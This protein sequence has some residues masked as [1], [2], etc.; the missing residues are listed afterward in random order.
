[1]AGFRIPLALKI[2]FLETVVI[3]SFGAHPS[4]EA[5]EDWMRTE[6]GNGY[7]EHLEK[8]M[9]LGNGLNTPEKANQEK[10][11][12]S[13][14]RRQ[15][16]ELL[17]IRQE[18]ELL[19]QRQKREGHTL[20]DGLPIFRQ[21]LTESPASIL[22][23]KD[24]A[25][26][27][28]MN[29]VFPYLPELSPEILN[30]PNFTW[31]A[32]SSFGGRTYLPYFTEDDIV[33]RVANFL[34]DVLL[35]L[36]LPL[37]LR[38]SLSVN[39]IRP[40]VSV[41]YAKNY[42][43]G[44]VEVR[45]TTKYVLESHPIVLGELLDQMLLVEG[46]YGMGPVIGILTTGEEWL[47]SWFPNDTM[48]FE[49]HDTTPTSPY[50]TPFIENSSATQTT[51][52]PPAIPSQA[53]CSLHSIDPVEVPNLDLEND[54]I[55]PQMHRML[56]TTSVL[57]IHDAPEVVLQ[58]LCGA[59]ELMSKS[60]IN[61]NAN[62]SRCLLKFHKDS[63]LITY[64]PVVFQD[65]YDS[66]NFHRFPNSNTKKLLALEDLGRGSNGIAWLCITLTRPSSVCV[67]KY[68]NH[69]STSH[70]EY[71]RNMWHFL[72]PEFTKMVQVEKWSGAFA[73]V[74]PH[75]SSV[76]EIEREDLRQELM[77]TLE[78]RFV[79]NRKVHQD[80]R[81]QNIGKYQKKEEGVGIILFD[82][83]S[84]VD[85]SDEMHL[86]WIEKAMTNLYGNIDV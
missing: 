9:R 32:T 59:F 30:A 78:E 43:V 67:L 23:E 12:L 53:L 37:Q 34:E 66:I 1:M 58:H 27:Q 2:H 85:Y 80:V 50:T 47:F 69:G 81:W 20:A 29:S 65:V 35:A 25:P 64:H 79:R 56:T 49:D 42:L 4:E 21:V 54:E 84:V 68:D 14:L 17:S 83:H 38:S 77:I 22:R 52:S 55:L 40:H 10:E 3:E 8:L 51:P 44:I 62:L 39:R 70:L 60:C 24:H 73:L 19:L 61:H 86:D 82:L 36:K 63:N 75:F 48:T 18:R 28:R 7:G 31:R 16:I 5:R 72:Y 76:L 15:E 33:R 41:I 45:K 6:A 13:I 57:N 74:M 71:E 46:F 11:L 26:C